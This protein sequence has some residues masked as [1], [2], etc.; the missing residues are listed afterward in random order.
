M[1][2]DNSTLRDLA[3]NYFSIHA[4]QRLTTFNFYIVV[5]SLAATSYFATFRADL[6]LTAAR[7]VLAC[8]LC[9]LAFVFW[10]L[11]QRNRILIKNA[12]RALKFFEQTCEIDDTAKVFTQ[13]EK[14]TS[15]KRTTG[16]R[17]AFF[18]QLHLSYSDCFNLVFA[19]FFLLGLFGFLAYWWPRI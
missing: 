18:W 11:D 2:D 3:W 5:S 4:S 15:S 14:E 17:R 13:E 9:L 1:K 10:K 8:L 16:W 12:E 19:L 7:P 6:H